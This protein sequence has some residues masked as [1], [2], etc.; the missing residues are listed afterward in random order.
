MLSIP[1]IILLLFSARTWTSWSIYRSAVGYPSSVQ[2]TWANN[3]DIS[4]HTPHSRIFFCFA[5]NSKHGRKYTQM[6]HTI[7]KKATQ[8]K[9]VGFLSK[10]S[11]LASYTVSVKPRLLF[12]SIRQKNKCQTA[13]LSMWSTCMRFKISLHTEKEGKGSHSG[14]LLLI[15]KMQ[16]HLNCL[17]LTLLEIFFVH[18]GIALGKIGGH[19]GWASTLLKLEAQMTI[20]RVHV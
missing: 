6:N 7:I 9:L 4:P 13:L 1:Q 19:S 16:M 15:T 12:L 10:L 5:F 17:T 14:G 3:R 18:R 11:S 2:L 20:N 8:L